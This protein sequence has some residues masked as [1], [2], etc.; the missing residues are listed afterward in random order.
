ML[1][2]FIMLI[3]ATLS[4]AIASSKGKS[5]VTWFIVG[6]LFP[7]PAV[8]VACCV[9]PEPKLDLPPDMRL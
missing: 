4:A 8:I 5:G 1:I 2:L 7:L 3:G 9:K 6:A